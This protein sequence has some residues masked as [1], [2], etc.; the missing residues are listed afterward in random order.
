MPSRNLTKTL[1]RS[2]WG[3]RR[4]KAWSLTRHWILGLCVP[5]L[6]FRFQTHTSAVQTSLREAPKRVLQ[7]YYANINLFTPRYPRPL[8][9]AEAS[10]QRLASCKEPTLLAND[11]HSPKGKQ[12]NS[13]TTLFMPSIINATLYKPKLL[14]K[15]TWCEF[16]F[17]ASTSCI[18]QLSRHTFSIQ[19]LEET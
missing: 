16:L 6:K 13:R 7:T 4:H 10:T 11:L 5:S 14:K 12:S 1:P 18:L 19:C 3:L 17:E 2:H 15:G 9:K 8:G